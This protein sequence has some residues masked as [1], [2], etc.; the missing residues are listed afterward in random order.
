MA[1][2][3]NAVQPSNSVVPDI[4]GGA[5]ALVPGG[6][7]GGAAQV[8]AGGGPGD[9]SAAGVVVDPSKPKT[10]FDA[11]LALPQ[12]KIELEF[13][14]DPTADV[15]SQFVRKSA[16]GWVERTSGK[17]MIICRDDGVIYDCLLE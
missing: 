15:G 5:G 14:V 9:G 6:D 8:V 10:L 1:A 12:S 16:K 11:Y 17:L 13:H 3:V 4:T 2:N 7:G